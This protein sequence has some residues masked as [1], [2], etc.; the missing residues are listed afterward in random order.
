[1]LAAAY[2]LVMLA[3]IFMTNRNQQLPF[4]DEIF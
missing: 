1:V 3:L 4:I 2:V